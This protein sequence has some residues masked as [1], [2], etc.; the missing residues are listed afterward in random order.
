[1]NREQFISR[2]EDTQKAFR[3]FLLAL[4]CGDAALADDIAQ[5]A[6]LKAFLSR[7]S[8]NDPGSF[9]AWIFRIGYNTFVSQKRSQ[10]EFTDYG[11][12]RHLAAPET[13]DSHFRYQDL[14]AALEALPPKERSSVLLYYMQGYSVKE[15][16]EIEGASQ[17]AVRQHLARG[18]S[19]LRGLLSNP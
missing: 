1:M 3:R 6:Y 15:I 19:H 18:R 5:E 12:A 13:S 2:V 17:V 10:K 7:D 9:N 14:Y 16:A 11:P 4:C 8:L